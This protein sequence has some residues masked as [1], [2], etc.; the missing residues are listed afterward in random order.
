MVFNSWHHFPTFIQK[1]AGLLDI[2]SFFYYLP[3]NKKTT[4]AS[5]NGLFISKLLTYKQ[6]N[7]D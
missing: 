5:N 6:D 2:L 7:P 1:K 4:V 3:Q